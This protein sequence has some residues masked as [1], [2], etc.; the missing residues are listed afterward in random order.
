MV[1]SQNLLMKSRL[2][3]Y[4][5]TAV[6]FSFVSCSKEM[7]ME[8]G[9]GPDGKGDFYATVDGNQW[10]ADSIQLV[11][12]GNNGVSISGLSKTGELISMVLPEFKTGSYTLDAQSASYS[13]YL[14]LL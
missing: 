6:L 12:V 3:I 5:L 11:L 2:T 14:N 8:N 13:F 10:N 1:K 7:S 9:I 4:I